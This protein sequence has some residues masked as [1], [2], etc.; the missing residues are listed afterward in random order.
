MNCIHQPKTI[1]PLPGV[2]FLCGSIFSIQ[3]PLFHPSQI[4]VTVHNHYWPTAKHKAK[5]KRVEVHERD[6]K[7]DTKLVLGVAIHSH[8]HK[9]VIFI[10]RPHP[11]SFKR[12]P[13]YNLRCWKYLRVVIILH[14]VTVSCMSGFVYR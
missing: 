13:F 10:E 4:I 7:V 9:N 6:A 5:H 2:P 11:Q 8:R 12:Q 14:S 3:Q 1:P